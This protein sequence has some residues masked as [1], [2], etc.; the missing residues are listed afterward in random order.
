VVLSTRHLCGWCN[1]NDGLFFPNLFPTYNGIIIIK[2]TTQQ[3]FLSSEKE[4]DTLLPKIIQKMG[5]QKELNMCW[6]VRIF[7]LKIKNPNISVEAF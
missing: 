7:I 4:D 5:K 2:I 3:H 6:N 1:Q